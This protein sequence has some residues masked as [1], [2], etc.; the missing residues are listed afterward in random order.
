M[1]DK[2]IYARRSQRHKQEP[3]I[4]ENANQLNVAEH[5]KTNNEINQNILLKQHL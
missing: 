1:S 3:D 2:N 5:R 4:C